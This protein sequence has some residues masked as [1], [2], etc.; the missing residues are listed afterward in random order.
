MICWSSHSQWWVSCQTGLPLVCSERMI[1][2]Q[3]A[4]PIEEICLLIWSEHHIELQSRCTT[5]RMLTLTLLFTG[6][7]LM[8]RALTSALKK[9]N[10]KARGGVSDGDEQRWPLRLWALHHPGLSGV[11]DLCDDK[12]KAWHLKMEWLLALTDLVSSGVGQTHVMGLKYNMISSSGFSGGLVVETE[13][14]YRAPVTVAMVN[15]E[16]NW[17]IKSW[18]HGCWTAL[19]M[20][21]AFCQMISDYNKYRSIISEFEWSNPHAGNWFELGEYSSASF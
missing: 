3:V 4:D 8:S 9:V 7:W 19:P 14:T 17:S 13:L 12:R 11:A 1:L 16:L 21:I 10:I 6:L 15:M 2:N 18:S 20:M 5:N